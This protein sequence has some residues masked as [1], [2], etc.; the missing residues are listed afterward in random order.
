VDKHSVAVVVRDERGWFLA[1]KRPDDPDDPLAGVWGL[2]AVTLRHNEDEHAA[3]ER[4]GRD[5]LGVT[6]RVGRKIGGKRADRGTYVLHLSDY[7]ATIA[8]GIPTVP[9][10]DPTVTQYTQAQFTDDDAILADA[11]AKGSLCAQIFLEAR[12]TSQTSLCSHMITH[13][14][15]AGGWPGAAST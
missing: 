1:V 15:R 2:P 12:R 10:T 14:G 5:K 3:A 7:E 9:G 13:S 4:V 6:L 8:H 11:A